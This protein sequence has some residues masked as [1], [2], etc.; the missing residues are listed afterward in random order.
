MMTFT[1]SNIVPGMMCF[2][3]LLASGGCGEAPPIGTW[4]PIHADVDVDHDDNGVFTVYAA[5]PGVADIDKPTDPYEAGYELRVQLNQDA[6]RLVVAQVESLPT[7]LA[8]KR[9]HDYALALKLYDAEG[10]IIGAPYVPLDSRNETWQAATLRYVP[11]RPV[12]EA[13]IQLRCLAQ[14]GS[15]QFRGPFI[16]QDTSDNTVVSIDGI[17]VAADADVTAGW[18][19]H[20]LGTDALF[21]MHMA[22][23]YGLEA[24]VTETMRDEAILSELTITDTTGTDRPLQL[25]Y[26][27]P[28]E[29]TEGRQWHMIPDAA[30]DAQ[31]GEFISALDCVM[32][33]GQMGQW[34]VAATTLG[35][36]GQA[37]GFDITQPAV[38]RLGM[39]VDAGVLY[40]AFD[41]AVTPEQPT[42]TVGAVSYTFTAETQPFRHALETYYAIFPESFESR[43]EAHGIW[44]PFG[45]V[46][47]IPNWEDFGFRFI[48]GVH[49][50]H[51]SGSVGLLSFHYV[52]PL[53]WWMWMDETTPRTAESAL[54]IVPQR[55]EDGDREAASFPTSVFRDPS[56][57]P[58]GYF[59]A[60]PW[61]D[62][63]VWSMNSAPGMESPNHFEAMWNDGARDWI[64]NS[65]DGIHGVAGVYFD[66]IEGY[67][68]EE[69]NYARG[70]FSGMD[71]PMTFDAY[72]RPVIYKGLI[73]FETLRAIADDL[74]GM[75]KYT[76]ANTTPGRIC[77]LAPQ[78]D[79]LGTETDWNIGGEWNPP[80]R[81]F[82]LFIR[83]LTGDKPYC[84][85]MNS[86]FNEFTYDHTARYLRRCVAFG[87]YPGFFS[88]NAFDGN[89]WARPDLYERDRPLF[90]Q[91]MPLARR[92]GEAG[93]E[94]V[95]HA[96]TVSEDVYIERFGDDLLTVF[97]DNEAEQTITITLTGPMA[98][99]SSATNL[100]TDEA[101][102]INYS[103]ITITLDTEDVAVI[104]FK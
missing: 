84:F 99:F 73:V 15:A 52:E 62:G 27:Q 101:V 49:E 70:H 61:C 17:L 21:P 7:G 50:S 14:E 19:I 34:P 1:R 39:S 104:E 18:W 78:L 40:A 75:D 33:R 71:T 98:E 92:V 6:P 100:A 38:Y 26:I 68:T 67:I 80:G 77:Y 48:E 66:S 54:A 65:G 30:V 82:L 42:A 13:V 102:T 88:P 87:M 28:I 31:A 51:W 35:N 24:T 44:M 10:Q 97:N 11:S 41:V 69:M 12:A 23:A 22:Q 29:G 56:G 8:T 81:D 72:G 4:A 36:T 55:A 5:R 53:T 46:S 58:R 3:M 74:H 86:N 57:R 32:G 59:V 9:E 20:E 60:A 91:Y 37:I 83:A 25:L 93:W 47:G 43:L 94:P 79:V 16:T 45:Y 63:I 64:A 85:L 2:L 96:A 95:T 76:M 90:R 89:Y 103:T